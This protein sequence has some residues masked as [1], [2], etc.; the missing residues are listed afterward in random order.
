V[1]IE[2]SQPGSDHREDKRDDECAR[3]PDVD[4][5]RCP[6]I[7]WERFGVLCIVSHSS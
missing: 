3:L 1:P 4:K 2:E 5:C 6:K 7:G